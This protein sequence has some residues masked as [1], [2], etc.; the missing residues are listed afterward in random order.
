LPRHRCHYRASAPARTLTNQGDP[1]PNVG[2]FDDDIRNPL[3]HRTCAELVTLLMQFSHNSWRAKDKSDAV[4]HDHVLVR[5][6]RVK[7]VISKKHFIM[8]QSKG[9]SVLRNDSNLRTH[10]LGYGLPR[11]YYDWLCGW[12][13]DGREFGV[14]RDFLSLPIRDT[15]RTTVGPPDS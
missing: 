3:A 12:A 8:D 15:V 14:G 5:F 7:Q 10:G 9:R 13:V 6:Y 1:D 2:A 11:R 4:Q